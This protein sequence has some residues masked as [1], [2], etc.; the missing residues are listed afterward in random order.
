[1]ADYSQE[2]Q[3]AY[4]SI[5]AAGELSSWKHFAPPGITQNVPMVFFPDTRLAYAWIIQKPDQPVPVGTQIALMPNVNF[6]PNVKDLIIRAS[7]DE[8][9][10]SSA[11]EL[12]LN[13][14]VILWTLNITR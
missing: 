3:D 9:K 8:Y 5:L 1:M 10:L 7:G 12:N 14:Q 6:V 4:D 2:Q 11:N 13:G